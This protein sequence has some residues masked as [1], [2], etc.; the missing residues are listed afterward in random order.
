MLA[1]AR[2]DCLVE[3][4]DVV[5]ELV[6]VVVDEEDEVADASHAFFMSRT[7]AIPD[8]KMEDN[9]DHYLEGYIQALIE[10]EASPQEIKKIRIKDRGAQGIN[11]EEEKAARKAVSELKSRADGMLTIARLP[12]NRTSAINKA[13][14]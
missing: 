14:T 6:D 1:G 11:Q 3:V 4:V 9:T 10:A 2:V 7:E 12:H 13:F 8:G 5:V